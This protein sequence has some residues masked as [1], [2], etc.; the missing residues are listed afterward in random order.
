MTIYDTPIEEKYEINPKSALGRGSFGVVKLGLSR[1]TG[2]HYAI[3]I[4]DKD[5]QETNRL[6]REVKLLK[7]VDHVNI[8]GLFAVYET[9][10][11]V[12]LSLF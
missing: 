3:K 9:A 5:K 6:E 7:D 10:S 1:E 4:V 12:E 11:Q 8:V 2:Q